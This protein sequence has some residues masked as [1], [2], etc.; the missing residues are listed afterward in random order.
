MFSFSFGKSGFGFVL[1]WLFAKLG[2]DPAAFVPV[3]FIA[4]QESV[5]VGSA[6]A[7]WF[8]AW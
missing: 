7:P 6:D 8:H 1:P 3:G 2:Y 4:K 5:L